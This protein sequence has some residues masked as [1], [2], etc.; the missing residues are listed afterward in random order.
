MAIYNQSC[1]SPPDRLTD[2]NKVL[3]FQC[4]TMEAQANDIHESN[5]DSFVVLDAIRVLQKKGRF[6]EAIALCQD[7]IGDNK[8]EVMTIAPYTNCYHLRF[9][10]QHVSSAPQ[11]DHSVFTS[12]IMQQSKEVSMRLRNTLS[13]WLETAHRVYKELVELANRFKQLLKE[14]REKIDDFIRTP[15][16][17]PSAKERLYTQCKSLFEK[18]NLISPENHQ[19]TMLHTLFTENRMSLKSKFI[20]ASIA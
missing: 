9:L 15:V 20:S 6:S 5:G 17:L 14:L 3:E 12:N 1:K 11:Q 19:L 16:F 4:A 2:L 13:V 8:T 18:A 10:M 7:A